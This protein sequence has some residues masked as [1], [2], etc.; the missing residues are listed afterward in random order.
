[1]EAPRLAALGLIIGANK[2]GTAEL[3][4]LLEGYA[5]ATWNSAFWLRTAR[6]C[7]W[8]RP[9][10]LGLVSRFCCDRASSSKLVH[11][12]V[13]SL[14]FEA[15]AANKGVS[16]GL[17]DGSLEGFL[18]FWIVLDLLIARNGDLWR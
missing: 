9:T 8:G 16:M 5:A 18:G 15:V 7:G 14:L 11:H 6:P 3:D 1:M 2:I 12:F 10:G 13:Y 4:F 17:N